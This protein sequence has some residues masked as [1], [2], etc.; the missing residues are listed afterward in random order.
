MN[1][2]QLVIAIVL[3][4]RMRICMLVTHRQS[5]LCWCLDWGHPRQCPWKHAQ[6]GGVRKGGGDAH[7]HAS[8]RALA[9]GTCTVGCGTSSKPRRAFGSWPRAGPP[10]Y[11]PGRRGA[12]APG[13]SGPP[14]ALAL[15]PALPRAPAADSGLDAPGKAVRSTVSRLSRSNRTM[16]R[17]ALFFFKFKV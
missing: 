16:N 9:M 12:R 14:P 8:A 11:K 17:T 6:G 13:R 5:P 4:M 10:R 7:A 2:S 15:G 3:Y 1:I